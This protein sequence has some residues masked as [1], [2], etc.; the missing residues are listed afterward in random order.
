MFYPLMIWLGDK[1]ENLPISDIL[2]LILFFILTGIILIAMVYNMYFIDAPKQKNNS[3]FK[4]MVVTYGTLA[5]L[6]MILIWTM[7]SEYMLNLFGGLLGT[8]S[9]KAETLKFIGSG[10]VGVFAVIGTIMGYDRI[11]EEAN[12]NR[13]A[14][15]KH[16]DEQFNSAS[17]NLRDKN[18]VARISALDQFHDL[19]KHYNV[20]DFRKRIF[21]TLCSHLC[22]SFKIEK[23]KKGPITQECQTLLD[24]LFKFEGECIFYEFDANLQDVYLSHA[25]LRQAKLSSVNLSNA[26]L[27]DADFF[28]ANIQ[29]AMLIRT[30]LRNAKIK[31]VILYNACFQCARL[32]HADLSFSKFAFTKFNND[33]SP[34]KHTRLK[35][36]QLQ[37][38]DFSSTVHTNTIFSHAKLNKA[39]F[40]NARLK[41][42][43]F[44][45]TKLYKAN[46]DQLQHAEEV[47]FTDANLTEAT[48]ISANISSA[49]LDYP[50]LFCAN[51]LGAELMGAKFT[52]A[53]LKKVNF[54]NAKLY[55]ADFNQLQHAEE[56]DF[57]NADL[58][59]AS[60]QDAKL[61][62][63]KLENVLSLKG[64]DFRGATKNNTLMTLDDIPEKWRSQVK[65]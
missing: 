14:E 39:I 37:H 15:K 64:A 5:F 26:D 48:F 38:A 6:L 20:V 12:R 13:L 32:E 46:F 31:Y 30:N 57:T 8:K 55:K 29:N 50:D 16:R 60:F 44:E 43:N 58:T 2:Q 62:K 52:K 23:F 61:F 10:V 54:K 41:K 1:T 17:N 49:Q 33:L 42:V 22:H 51:F 59:E 40:R 9:S 36:A 28:G 3:S 4:L 47:D 53:Y 19:A 18:S 56:V 45:K 27:S 35:R 24:I 11:N 34:P 21:D 7:F 65:I 25:N 63:I